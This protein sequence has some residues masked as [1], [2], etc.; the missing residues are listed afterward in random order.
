LKRAGEVAT[1]A[2]AADALVAALRGAGEVLRRHF[3]RPGTVHYKGRGNPVTA[4]D[5][6]ADRF[7]RRSLARRF[8]GHGFLTEESRPSGAA[9]RSRWI[10]DPL[11]GT[12]NFAHGLPHAC[13][14]VAYERDGEL[15]VGGVYDPF[16]E[17]LFL[18]V[19]GRGARLNGRPMRVSPA[20]R[21]A[22]A[23]L[24]TGFPYDRHRRAAVYAH[25]VEEF[26]RRG[27]DVRRL[28]A[29]ALDLAYVACGRL[30]GYWEFNLRPWDVAAGALLV[31]EA[32]GRVTDFRGRTYRME[33][34]SQTL[35]T[36]GRVHAAMLRTLGRGAVVL[37][38]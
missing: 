32:G 27:Q 25:Y 29:A 17:E 4:A 31:R 7:V 9:A 28:G 3:R 10:V 20:A 5:R 11:D 22:E 12:V 35:A 6:E 34:T 21:L 19:R 23:L 36:N 26:L 37:I 24:V 38:K 1:D 15:R 2:R 16:R 14:S 18:A 13:V 8:P 33:D 30:D